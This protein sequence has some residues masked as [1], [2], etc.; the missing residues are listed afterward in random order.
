[1]LLRR[2]LFERLGCFDTRYAPA[3]Y[4]GTDLAFAVRA[5][6]LKVIYVPRARVIH[7]GG[8]TAGTDTGS[9][10]KRFQLVNQAKFLDK[11]RDALARQP[12]PG[13]PIGI[14]ASHRAYRRVLIIDATTP[15]PDQ[16][17]GSLRMVNLMRV[18]R[19][20]DCHV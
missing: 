10:M 8:I 11:W 17:S 4:E 15:T 6:G 18:L 2:A 9:G 19:G 1:I 14:A 13:T 12:T 20:N 5:A 16:D 7:F 3:Y